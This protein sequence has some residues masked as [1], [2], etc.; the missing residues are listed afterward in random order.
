MTYGIPKHNLIK[1][2]VSLAN[3]QLSNQQPTYKKPVHS[4]KGATPTFGLVQFFATLD[5]LRI[6]GCC[7]HSA[8]PQQGLVRLKLGVCTPDYCARS[9]IL[10][11]VEISYT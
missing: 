6:H 3:E 9:Q 2:H 10:M 8:A 1:Y 11:H 7:P 5:V 4:S